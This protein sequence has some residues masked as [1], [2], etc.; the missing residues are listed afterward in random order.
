MKLL[1]LAR[2]KPGQSDDPLFDNSQK[3]DD[4]GC[5][6]Q[7]VLDSGRQKQEIT[8]GFEEDSGRGKR[9]ATVDLKEMEQSLSVQEEMYQKEQAFASIDTENSNCILKFL[10]NKK[11][12]VYG[13]C[14]FNIDQLKQA[15]KNLED[16]MRTYKIPFCKQK[17]TSTDKAYLYASFCI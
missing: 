16:R 6:I 2:T 13:N 7:D 5:K 14:S 17:G 1:S 10:T 12:V 8:V 3:Q 9:V 11:I 15:I 4:D